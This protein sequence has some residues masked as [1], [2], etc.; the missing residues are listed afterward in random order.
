MIIAGSDDDDD[1]GDDDANGTSFLKKNC[2]NQIHFH[3]LC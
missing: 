1:D 3:N 2:R